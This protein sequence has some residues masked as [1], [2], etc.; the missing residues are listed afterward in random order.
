[1][2]SGTLKIISATVIAGALVATVSLARTVHTRGELTGAPHAISTTTTDTG[3][4]GYARPVG[5]SPAAERGILACGSVRLDCE[6][7]EN[8][9]A[10]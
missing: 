6:A 1:M 4:V 5:A 8:L 10:Q 2:I 9:L 3:T 7:V